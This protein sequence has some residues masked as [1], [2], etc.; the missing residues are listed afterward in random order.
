MKAG[1]KLNCLSII[2]IIIFMIL[3]STLLFAAEIVSFKGS[4]T[5]KDGTPLLLTVIWSSKNRH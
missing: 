4:S 3:T 5:T 1:R 2:G